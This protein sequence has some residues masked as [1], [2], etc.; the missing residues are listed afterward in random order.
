MG[1]NRHQDENL[2]MQQASRRKPLKVLMV[3][4][5]ASAIFGGEAL[6]PFQYFKHLRAMD[7]DVHL[8]VHA[9]TEKELCEA[10]PNDKHRL[11][12]VADSLVNIWC[13]KIGQLMPDRLAV[14]TV[15]AIS[16]FDTQMRQRRL[17]RF[18]IRTH[19]FDVVHEPIPVSPKLPSMMFGL[20]APVIVGPMNGGMDYPV[21]YN[22]AGP[23][24]RSVVWIL[25]W[26]AALWNKI[27]PGKKY[28]ALLLVANE[29]TY[30]A[31]PFNIK[32]KRILKIVENGVDLS[33]FSARSVWPASEEVSIVY[34]GRLVDW[35]RVDLLIDACSKLVGKV[36]FQVDIVG[37]GPL[38]HALEEQV[39]QLS[40]TNRVQFHGRLAQAAAA[41]LLRNSDIM[42]L[43]SM[44]ECGGAVVLEAMASGVPVI[45]AKWG[46]P[47]DYL[48]GDTGV[49]IPPATP[50]IFV[51]ELANTVCSMAKSPKL[52]AQ[53]GQA[54]ARRARL[55][56]DW[57]VK[58][59]TILQI[60]E[61]VVKEHIGKQQ[62][63]NI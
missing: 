8:L 22:L 54:G 25:R 2:N 4:E 13:H 43:P 49:L 56:Y 31:L 38:R 26:T 51:R 1:A 53:M 50:K 48:T 57:R 40:L 46:G 23:L 42:V 17:A 10:F 3:A 34:I 28:A 41:E 39:R 44:R 27:L 32:K 33:R 61:D 29:R 6:I 24:E 11:H 5:H 37:D 30:K 63:V 52:R 35:K 18:L 19:Y 12:F 20:S 55:L 7:V 60:Y 16:H 36:N 62:S 9:R 14:F 58:A 45:A 15:R 21:H 59:N 47:E